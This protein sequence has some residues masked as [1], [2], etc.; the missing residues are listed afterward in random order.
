MGSLPPAQAQPVTLTLS[1][2]QT[3]AQSPIP[4]KTLLD[5][6][7]PESLGILVVSNLPPHFPQLRTRV[8]ANISRLSHLPSVKLD[9]L[10]NKDAKYLVGWSHG[11]ESLRPGVVDT[12]KGS[13]YVNCA[14]DEN[15]VVLQDMRSQFAGFEEYTAPNVWPDELDIPGFQQDVRELVSLIVDVAGLVAKAVDGFAESMVQNYPVHT[16]NDIGYLEGVVRGSRTSKARLLHYF[17][18]SP[19]GSLLSQAAGTTR[20]ENQV[21]DTWCTTHLDHGCL[22]GLT[23]AAFL[24]E[25]STTPSSDHY[26]ELPNSPSPSAGLYILDR[27]SK[28]HKVSI[29]RD[30][31]A[32]QTGEALERITKGKLKAV[33]HFVQGVEPSEVDEGQKIARNTLAVF[34]QPNLGDVV[35]LDSG[36][37][38]GEFARG[39]VHKNTIG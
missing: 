19:E 14:F 11:K 2:L 8:L 25:S 9:Q 22:T 21:N 24:D 32:F 29:P 36:L 3:Q 5:A 31:L 30:C 6:F 18:S 33:P 37:T 27:H 35:D 20:T 23:S 28:I 1:S 15:D 38:F 39:V 4:A 10:V 26:A 16:E 12:A 34:T 7:G 13:Y 17:P